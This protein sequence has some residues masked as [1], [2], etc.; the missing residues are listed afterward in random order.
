VLTLKRFDSFSRRDFDNG[1]VI[2]EIRDALKA[3]E[4]APSASDNK[5]SAAIAKIAAEMEGT[6]ASFEKIGADMRRS[7]VAKW[8]RQLRAL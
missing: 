3:L 5:Q 7:D 2:S 1:A 6:V 4:T 8:A